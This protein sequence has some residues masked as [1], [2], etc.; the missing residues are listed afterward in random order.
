MNIDP[1]ALEDLKAAIKETGFHLSSPQ[2]EINGICNK[3]FSAEN[4]AHKKTHI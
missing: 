2:L 3:C 4:H 1:L